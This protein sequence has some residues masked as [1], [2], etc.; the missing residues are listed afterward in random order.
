MDEFL[1]ELLHF[2]HFQQFIK[3]RMD[4]LNEHRERD[5]FDEEAIVFDEGTELHCM[6][7]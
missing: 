7:L 2:Q 5:I 4:R 3:N 6:V 1:G